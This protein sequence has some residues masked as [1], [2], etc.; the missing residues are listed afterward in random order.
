M[1]DIRKINTEMKENE[2]AYQRKLNATIAEM[3]TLK[4]FVLRKDFLI[5]DLTEKLE[6]SRNETNHLQI[7]VDKWNVSKKA[8]ADIIDC[9]RQSFVKDGIGYKDKKGIEKSLFLP[10][11]KSEYIP[12]PKPHPKN[13]L[14][15][16][17]CVTSES[18]SNMSKSSADMTQQD[19]VD[20]DESCGGQTMGLGH[21]G[22]NYS[23]VNWFI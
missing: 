6:K 11:S 17:E 16:K 8:H 2:L 10:L 9:S 1:D 12:I 3:Q 21:P 5:N 13:D 18:H 7:V 19:Q 4:E 15:E 20:D 23:T 14:F 22:A